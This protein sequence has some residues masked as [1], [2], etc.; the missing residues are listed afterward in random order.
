MQVITLLTISKCRVSDTQAT[1]KA[2]G[3]LKKKIMF[4]V[5]CKRFLNNGTLF[6]SFLFFNV[7]VSTNFCLFCK[8]LLFMNAFIVIE[9]FH[10]AY[11]YSLYVYLFVCSRCHPCDNVNMQLISILVNEKQSTEHLFL[12]S[13]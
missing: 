5:N 9:I 4:D 11:D 10:Y 2:C 12:N 7:H 6:P 13:C 3:I 1:I 8:Y